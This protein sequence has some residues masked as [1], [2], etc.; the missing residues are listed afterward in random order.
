MLGMLLLMQ[1]AL[2]PPRTTFAEALVA[3]VPTDPDE[4]DLEY[5][6][7]SCSTVDGLELPVWDLA[8]VPGGPTMLWLHDH[9]ESRISA[10]VGIESWLSWCGRVVLVDLRGH[11]DAPGAC[12]LGRRE[13]EDVDRLL[14]RIDDE[15]M[16]LAGRGFGGVLALDAARRHDDLAVW[17][18]APRVDLNAEISTTLRA[19]H[20]PSWP[21]SALVVSAASLLG[22]RP[23][24][25]VDVQADQRIRIIDVDVP[26]PDGPWWP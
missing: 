22:S 3:G 14:D 21:L 26:I 16:I 13:G 5:R 23:I 8:G 11:G 10:L 24:D 6:T 19:H 20:L 18:V 4:Q 12:T 7:W 1:A 17:A 9:G 2:R 15:R 25:P